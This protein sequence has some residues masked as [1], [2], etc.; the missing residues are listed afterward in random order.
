MDYNLFY[1]T[2]ASN[3]KRKA[4]Q[5]PPSGDDSPKNSFAD[6]ECLS[7][8]ID[9]LIVERDNHIYLYAKICTETAARLNPALRALEEEIL[10]K[11]HYSPTNKQCIYLHISSFGGSIFAAFSI[12]DTIRSLKVPVVSIIEGGSASAATL[13]SVCCDYRMIHE[14]SFMLIH[15]LSSCAWGK[16]E[17]IKEEV[18][19]LERLMEEIRKI[20]KKHTTIEDNESSSKS[21]G[22]KKKTGE[23]LLDE[24]LKHDLWWDS[25]QCLKYGLVDEIVSTEKVFEFDRSLCKF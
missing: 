13:I 6:I 19:N 24:I 8:S 2:N 21:G 4:D 20:Y 23:S 18:V 11:N 16:M 3:R 5:K 7:G 1:T 12:I 25:E 17:D 10:L 9:K 15:Q 14:S 22:K